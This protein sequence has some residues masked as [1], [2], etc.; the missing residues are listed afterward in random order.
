MT[1]AF[2]NQTAARVT[3]STPG[4]PRPFTSLQRPRF[5]S[6]TS[7]P[8]KCSPIVM[9]IGQFHAHARGIHQPASGPRCHSRRGCADGAALPAQPTVQQNFAAGLIEESRLGL[10]SHAGTGRAASCETR[11]DQHGLAKCFLSRL[12]GLHADAGIRAEPRRI[13]P[14]GKPGPDCID[15]R[16]SGAVA[17]SSFA[18]RRCLARSWNSHRGHYESDSPPGSY[19]HALCQSPRHRHHISGRE[20]TEHSKEIAAQTFPTTVW[21]E[22]RSK[23]TTSILAH[24]RIQNL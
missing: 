21:R 23:E 7:P 1:F 8:M 24:D 3:P 11:F 2:R 20:S 4:R 12:C 6:G 16:R 22:I 10:R 14:V 19:A 15:V 9:T 17:L 18:H 13:D 5:H